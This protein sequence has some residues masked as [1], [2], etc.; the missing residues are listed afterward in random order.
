MAQYAHGI[1]RTRTIAGVPQM[2]GDT[3]GPALSDALLLSTYS[4]TLD[5]T[6]PEAGPQLIIG[7]CRLVRCLNL[8]T[9]M[10]TTIAGGDMSGRTSRL[11]RSIL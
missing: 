11:T 2:S 5:M 10:V 8:R 7:D 9:E 3:D 4:L 1:G 6:D